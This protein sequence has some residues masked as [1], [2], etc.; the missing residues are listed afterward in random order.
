MKKS[1]AIL[2]VTLAAVMLGGCTSQKK[3]QLDEEALQEQTDLSNETATVQK[4]LHLEDNHDAITV[5]DGF[6]LAEICQGYLNEDPTFS[7]YYEEI[8]EGWIQIKGNG[9]YYCPAAVYNG[10]WTDF[11]AV[12]QSYWD[13]SSKWAVDFMS[14]AYGDSEDM[15]RVI[16]SSDYEYKLIICDGWLALGE[17]ELRVLPI[18]TKTYD[19]DPKQLI[20]AYQ[21]GEWDGRRCFAPDYCTTARIAASG[22]IEYRYEERDVL[23]EGLEQY[24]YQPETEGPY[25]DQWG[26]ECSPDVQAYET[27]YVRTQI[28]YG[29]S[30]NYAD[31]P[32][33]KAKIGQ[34][35]S[36]YAYQFGTYFLTTAGVELWNKGERVQKWSR[37]VDDLNGS[38]L[39]VFN[40]IGKCNYLYSEGEIFYLNPAGTLDPLMDHLVVVDFGERDRSF[41]AVSLK[42][43]VLS[44]GKRTMGG[45][46]AQ[47]LAQS[48]RSAIFL[49]DSV[50]FVDKTG[51]YFYI[52]CRESEYSTEPVSPE[53][54]REHVEFAKD[55]KDAETYEEALEFFADYLQKADD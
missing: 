35:E 49:Q 32:K 47:Q 27:D 9:K 13:K 5:I 2:V 1:Y 52:N 38:L 40:D 53:V 51:D 42:E 12:R 25:F 11:E 55:K 22:R 48:V 39:G 20:K 45:W 26:V 4:D 41:F 8:L 46:E 37:P 30:K 14:M 54:M 29:F 44:I 15:P 10:D 23:V 34:H 21:A 24:L 33:L 28:S 18:D 31:C 36:R 50:F 6:T 7:D 16:W 19:L 43:G 3:G 17:K